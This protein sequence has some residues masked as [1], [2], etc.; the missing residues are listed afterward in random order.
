M[1][2]KILIL[3]LL[4]FSI[5]GI[6]QKPTLATGNTGTQLVSKFNSIWDYVPARSSTFVIVAS[7]SSALELLQADYVC[8]GTADDVQINAAIAAM[9]AGGGSIVLSSGLFTTAAAIVI[10]KKCNL[11]GAGA[12]LE[13]DAGLTTIKG[14]GAFNLIEVHGATKLRGI[15]IIDLQLQ[16]SSKTNGKSGLYTDDTDIIYVGNI[17]SMNSQY[18]FDLNNDDA[19]T[20]FAFGGQ[21][22]G[23]GMKMTSCAYTRIISGTIADNDGDITLGA[24]GI[25]STG[26]FNVSFVANQIVRTGL[27]NAVYMNTSNKN[28]FFACNFMTCGKNAIYITGGGNIVTGCTFDTWGES[29]VSGHQNA[30]LL[31]NAGNTI[32]SSNVIGTV[33]GAHQVNGVLENTGGWPDF[34]L[35][36]G[37]IFSTITGSNFVKTGASSI[38]SNNISSTY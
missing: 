30:I 32:I 7:N 25:Y 16:G 3:F 1:K 9:P 28:C 6:A 34:N 8:D 29:V 24:G 2:K 27:Y 20:F 35:V 26:C 11:R 36:T 22:C 14:A 19:G 38:D 23:L 10:N 12:G 33:D 15:K 5:V 4:S 13:T 18:G 17:S 31:F 21:L 37:N